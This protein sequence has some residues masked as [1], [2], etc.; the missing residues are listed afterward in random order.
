M[1]SFYTD[2]SLVMIP[3]GYKD[4]KVYCAKPVDG[5]ADLTFSRGSDIEATRVASNGYIQ[6]AKVNSLLQSNNFDTTWANV[7]TTETS[8]QTGYDGSSDAWKLTE[9]N[10]S[11]YHSI[12]QT[13]TN[14]GLSTLSIYAKTDGR[15]LQIRVNGIGSGKAFVNYDLSAGSVGL[16]GGTALIDSSIESIGGGWYRCSFAVNDS[17]SYGIDILTITDASTSTE[18]QQYLGDNTKGI[19]IQDAQI[20][21][22]LVAQEYQETTTTSVVSGITNDMPRL[23][24]SGGASCPSLL[25]EPSR[26]NFEL[27]SEYL[28][29]AAVKDNVVITTNA[30]TSPEGIDNASSLVDDATNGLHRFYSVPSTTAAS[31][32]TITHSIFAKANGHDWFQLSS[33]GQTND[34]WANFDLTNGV[35]GNESASANADI[36]P[37]ANG[38]YRCVINSTTSASNAIIGTLPTL[39]NDTDAATRSPSYVG[40]G[41]GVFLYGLQVEV[42]SYPTSLIPTYGTSA[43]RTAEISYASNQFNNIGQTEGTIYAEF[44]LP[45]NITSGENRFALSDNTLNN[46]FFVSLPESGNKT[47]MYLRVG[48][49]TA[50][51]V[52][53]ASAVFNYGAVNKVAMAYKSGDSRVYVNGVSVLSSTNSFGT[54]TSELDV[55]VITGS[56]GTGSAS[57]QTISNKIKQALLFKTRLSNADLATL[58][59]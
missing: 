21:Y 23:D 57:T 52:Q 45:V 9:Q 6:K 38:W 17:G 24:Y 56:S 42:G 36:Q 13:P 43:T 26:T 55:F 22:G 29:A 15:D 32:V 53:T 12:Y 51:D 33:G 34:Q 18:L 48:A 59:A 27:N 14:T 19:Y 47:R 28:N 1:S 37:M 16:S 41:N 8:G 54:P 10:V 31:G 2:A 5:S 49:S 25:L 11:G 44:F 30:T 7:D 46:W 39:T 35:I 50:V 58:T 4:Q 20:N 3:S 40:S